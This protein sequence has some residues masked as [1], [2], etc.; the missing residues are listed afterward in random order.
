MISSSADRFATKIQK[1]DEKLFRFRLKVV[2]GASRSKVAGWLG[3]AL[4]ITVAVAPEKGKANAAIEKLLAG[5][6]D[7]PLSQV[8]IVA[9]HT[10]PHKTIEVCGLDEAA[11]VERLQIPQDKAFKIFCISSLCRY[12]QGRGIKAGTF[13]WNKRYF[14]PW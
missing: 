6:L 9:G 2:P 12:F 5:F 8:S 4:K 10:H 3:D 11:L 13:C 7:L 14:S 1:L